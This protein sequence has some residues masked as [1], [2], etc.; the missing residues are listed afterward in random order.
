MEPLFEK[1]SK[2]VVL[3]GAGC[4]AIDDFEAEV[5]AGTTTIVP[6]VTYWLAPEVVSIVVKWPIVVTVE[7][8]VPIMVGVPV[9]TFP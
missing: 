5:T 7:T 6:L 3:V 4:E 9:F 2:E 8:P 1:F